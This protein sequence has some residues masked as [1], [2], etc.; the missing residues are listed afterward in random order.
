MSLLGG[1]FE[2]ATSS[3]GFVH[4]SLSVVAARLV[5]WR[6]S[7]HGPGVAATACDGP[8]DQ[9]LPRL[10]PLT[11]G[12]RPRE[13]LVSCGS[14]WTAYF[15]CSLQGT[16][17]VSTVGHLTRTGLVDGVAVRASSTAVQFEMFGPLPTEF[18]NYVR[19]VSVT[20][21]GSRWRF[22]ATGTVQWFEETAA[23][24]SRRVADRFTT[25]MLERYCQ[26]LGFEVF[27]GDAYGPD[28]MLIESPVA[29]P[30]GGHVMSFDEARAWRDR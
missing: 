3:I 18:L 17:A 12:V 15:D 20:K 4:E 16:D 28:A 5:E 9:L 29:P 11:G 8:L 1:R 30:P 22:D 6:R 24:E 13:L 21:D 2:P 14:G 25:A 27:D 19:T 7:Q 10:A 26:A 23:Y